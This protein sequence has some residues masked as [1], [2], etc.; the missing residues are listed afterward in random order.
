MK[1]IWLALQENDYPIATSDTLPNL[2]KG[3]IENDAITD[4]TFL[5]IFSE[6]RCDFVEALKGKDGFYFGDARGDQ[7]LLSYFNDLIE[8]YG[9]HWLRM[10]LID[11]TF[12]TVPYYEYSQKEEQ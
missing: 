3:M 9:Y 11:Y 12:F 5:Y 7:D 10:G 1:S 6:D 2:I 4:D 8:K